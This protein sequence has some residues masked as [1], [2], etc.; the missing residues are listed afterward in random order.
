M[1]TEKSRFPKV[2]RKG[3]LTAVESISSPEIQ[4]KRAKYLV[5]GMAMTIFF[6]ALWISWLIPN[7]E[8]IPYFLS[9]Q[10]NGSVTVSDKIG[11]RYIASDT[12]KTY[13]LRKFIDS[14]LLID[15]QT[16]FR[17]PEGANFVKGAA[18]TQWKEFVGKIDRPLAKLQ[19]DPTLRRTVDYD[20]RLEFLVGDKVSGTVSAF[21]IVK[22]IGAKE[23]KAKR[24]KIR[25]DYA[26]LPVTDSETLKKNPIGIYVTNIGMEDVK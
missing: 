18:L 9:E 3:L 21:L 20:G 26:M 8:Y 6:M 24:I 5:A 25:L 17:L 2:L 7:K 19:K 12:N 1:S 13:F 15:E 16:R 22:T 23:N 4:R 14:V 10:S 11:E